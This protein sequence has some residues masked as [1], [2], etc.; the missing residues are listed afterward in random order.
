M[1]TEIDYAPVGIVD[2]RDTL[3][4][5][6]RTGDLAAT[7]TAVDFGVLTSGRWVIDAQSIPGLLRIDYNPLVDTSARLVIANAALLPNAGSPVTITAH[8]YDRY[9]LDS[10]GNPLPGRGFAETLVYTVEAGATKELDG[11]G[12]D[13]VLGSASGAASPALATLLEGGFAAVWQGQ[14][15]AIW[16]Q[17]RDAAG[18]ARGAAF[19]VTPSSDGIL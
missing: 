10:Y 14:D 17:V 2:D 8:Y 18:T 7:L 11:F 15:S 6:L 13:L 5:T 3:F 16:A 1:S 4:T 12:S 9:Q 19:A